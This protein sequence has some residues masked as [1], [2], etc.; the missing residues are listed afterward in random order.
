M[1]N[2]E[3]KTRHPILL[4]VLLAWALVMIAPDLW[5]VVQPLGSYGFTANNDGLI[6]DVQGP[7][8]ALADSPAWAAGI[9]EGDQ[10]DLSRLECFPYDA[11]A[12]GNALAVL[13][14][15]QF[16]LPGR[17]ATFYLLPT[18]G[19]PARQVTLVAKSEP[20]NPFERFVVALDQIA[21][22]L[23]VLAAAWLV[24]T[25]P[26]AMSWGFF[27][28]VMW[29]NPGQ[30]Y[31]FYALLQQA[32]PVLLAQNAAECIAEAAG[33]MGLILFVLR[34]PNDTPDPR[35]RWLE[36]ALPAIGVVL[37]LGLMTSYGNLFDYRTENGTRAA[38]LIGLV[39]AIS[40]VSILLERRR[41]LAPEDYQRLR[42]VIWGCLIGLPAFILAE[43]ASTTT[44]FDT[45]W[46]DFTPPDDVI[47]LLY[48]VNGILCLF[49]FEAIRR[50][51]VVSVAIPLRRVTILGLTLSIPALLLHHEVEYLQEHLAIPNWAWLV[52]GAG[53][54][55][56]ISRLHEQATHL[57][58]RFFN[59]EL[60]RAETE[61]GQELLNASKPAEIDRLLADGLFSRLKLTS[62]AA[63]RLNGTTFNR[64]GDGHGW[65]TAARTLSPDEPMLEPLAKGAPFPIC[66]AHQGE[67]RLPPGLKR[68]ILAVPA[69]NPVRCFAL[70][71][72]GPH[73]SGT[74]L[75][76][77]ER[78]MLGRVAGQA[79]A[80]YAELES[81][82]LREKVVRLERELSEARSRPGSKP[83]QGA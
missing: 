18:T 24:W 79:A 59:R 28:Y 63:F 11:V 30:I 16:V 66:D 25:R 67:P 21:G 76:S 42:W 69:A 77:N 37:A 47:G 26:G 35:W 41:R 46:G 31:G 54:L 68:P 58:D 6:S 36:R 51:R 15:R 1:P 8:D 38:I 43:L 13:G 48:L 60:D 17:P 55:Y 49:V 9:R 65:A 52:V 2:I 73:V 23:V 3:P 44:I 22:I 29:F 40:A 53:A 50:E 7:F 14:G 71:L 83:K 10:L 20:A 39:V 82:D 57:T 34:A 12:C 45:A 75:D 33:Y 19:Q 27:L 72:Y 4:F 64:D 56:L 81:G 62:A 78:A 70:A 5:R 61:L 74:D 80:V 32:P